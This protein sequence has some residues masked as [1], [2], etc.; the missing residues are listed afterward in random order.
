[1]E[2]AAAEAAGTAVEAAAVAVGEVLSAVEVVAAVEAADGV[3]K[4]HGKAHILNGGLNRD[5]LYQ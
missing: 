1:V 4:C 5:C 2:A 3:D